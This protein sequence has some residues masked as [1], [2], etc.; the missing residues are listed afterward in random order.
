MHF[1]TDF[2]LVFFIIFSH[3]KQSQA[4]LCEFFY[5]K[6][7]KYKNNLP[8]IPIYLCLV[9]YAGIIRGRELLEVIDTFFCNFRGAGIIRG[10]ELLEVMNGL[11]MEILVISIL[12]KSLIYSTLLPRSV[13]P[14]NETCNKNFSLD[15]VQT[16]EKKT[17]Y[18]AIVLYFLWKNAS[19]D[20]FQQNHQSSSSFC[21]VCIEKQKKV[22]IT[23]GFFT[24]A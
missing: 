10:L 19:I 3:L 1:L 7:K 20:A 2:W 9:P 8:S 4:T 12:K 11:L 13:C 6:S 22:L 21:T 24:Y 18:R 15:F 5:F 23:L 16:I 17:L 14:W